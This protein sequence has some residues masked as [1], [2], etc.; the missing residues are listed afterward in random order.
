MEDGYEWDWQ[1]VDSNRLKYDRVRNKSEKSDKI[2]TYMVAS[3]FINRVIS[4]FDV[5]SI[6]RNHGR[7]VSFDVDGNPDDINM[8]LNFNF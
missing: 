7:L 5:L 1:G 6:K 3:L 2:K 4:T 8:S